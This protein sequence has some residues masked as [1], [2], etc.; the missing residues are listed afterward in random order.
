[1]KEPL[2]DIVYVKKAIKDGSI[3][4]QVKVTDI[5]LK[6]E[7]GECVLIGNTEKDTWHDE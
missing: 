2:I 4:V 5:Y 1:M 3:N 6:N 7:A